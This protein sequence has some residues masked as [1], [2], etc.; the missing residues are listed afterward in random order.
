MRLKVTVP[1]KKERHDAVV[2]V[3]TPAIAG[4]E[5][6]LTLLYQNI[7]HSIEWRFGRTSASRHT[8]RGQLIAPISYSLAELREL[9]EIGMSYSA[10]ASINNKAKGTKISSSPL[11]VDSLARTT[12][13]I[14]DYSQP[15]I[16]HIVGFW[17]IS[18]SCRLWLCRTIHK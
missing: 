14:R 1:L 3:A 10:E 4:L 9:S 18:N 2:K 15:I 5:K 17:N 12:N 16:M 8:G 13:R 6:H 7:S 11:I